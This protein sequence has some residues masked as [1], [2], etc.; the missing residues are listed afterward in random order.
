MGG[1]DQ[2]SLSID[3]VDHGDMVPAD[4]R[5]LR[6]L[7]D[8]EYLRDF[9]AWDPAPPCGRA[10]TQMVLRVGTRWSSASTCDQLSVPG[11][12]G[13]VLGNPC[14]WQD[15]VRDA[16]I[17]DSRGGDRRWHPSSFAVLMTP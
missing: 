11:L 13:L 16:I 9:G 4:L 12:C 1:A 5:E 7:F 17:T 15:C 3:V 14:L 10:V 2:V 8:S 6:R